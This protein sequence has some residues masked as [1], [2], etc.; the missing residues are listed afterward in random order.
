MLLLAQSVRTVGDVSASEKPPRPEP[1]TSSGA[2]GTGGG[3]GPKSDEK[4][5]SAPRPPGGPL[6][7]GAG[8]TGVGGWSP[9]TPEAARARFTALRSCSDCA[10]APPPPCGSRASGTS[11]SSVFLTRHGVR[12]TC[13]P[14][15]TSAAT[16]LATCAASAYRRRMISC[17]ISPRLA[18]SSAFF[19]VT[20]DESS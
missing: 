3:G 20:S 14:I 2:T 7:P 16:V 11:L 5:G 9:K 13:G 10:L 18:I 6:V 17:L 19:F 15:P 4:G 12:L 1:G 8:V